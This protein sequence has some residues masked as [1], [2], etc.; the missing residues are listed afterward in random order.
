[1]GWMLWVGP[2]VIV[3]VILIWVVV[4]LLASRHPGW[5]ASQRRETPHR[6]EVAGGTQLGS[7]SGANTSGPESDVVHGSDSDERTGEGR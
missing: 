5:R 7:P 3:A 6:G 2:I 1:M 4:T